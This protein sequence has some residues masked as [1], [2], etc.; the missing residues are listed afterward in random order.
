M[1]KCQSN[2]G[3]SNSKEGEGG[4]LNSV[5]DALYAEVIVREECGAQRIISQ[6]EQLREQGGEE[7]V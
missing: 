6:P 5:K 1:S 3:Y 4:N 2:I 7:C